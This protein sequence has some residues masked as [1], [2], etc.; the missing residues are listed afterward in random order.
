MS[1]HELTYNITIE[2][3]TTLLHCIMS[4]EKTHSIL[5][6]NCLS[7]KLSISLHLEYIYFLLPTA[8]HIVSDIFLFY[9]ILREN[10]KK[11]KR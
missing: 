10:L 2:S 9:S 7:S 8:P 6:L 3:K 4:N 11:E 5:I 1:E